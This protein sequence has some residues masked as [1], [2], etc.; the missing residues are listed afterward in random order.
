MSNFESDSV[1]SLHKRWLFTNINP[2]SEKFSFLIAILSLITNVA[3]INF[4]ITPHSIAD[5]LISLPIIAS[6]FSVTLVFDY[7]SLH[8][9]LKQILQSLTCSCICKSALDSDRNWRVYFRIYYQYQYI[10]H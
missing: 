1:S 2:S 9:T 8:H 5:F 6:V 7:L 4:V 3:L 10:E